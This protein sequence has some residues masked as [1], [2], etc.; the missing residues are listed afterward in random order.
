MK[1][2]FIIWFIDYNQNKKSHGHVSYEH[3]SFPNEEII[4]HKILE[5][6][7]SLRNPFITNI[8][9]LSE[10]DYKDWVG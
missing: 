2:Y 10:Q 1:R 9:E 4:K 3:T 5:S 8:I 6:D 7:S